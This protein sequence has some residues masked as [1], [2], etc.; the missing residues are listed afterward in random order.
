MV[1]A[2]DSSGLDSKINVYNPDYIVAAIVSIVL[3]ILFFISQTI[4]F[5]RLLIDFGA[6]DG[7]ISKARLIYIYIAG[8]FIYILKL[9]L[10][11]FYI[12][13]LIAMIVVILVL[14]IGLLKVKVP[15]AAGVT[16]VSGADDL[17]TNMKANVYKRVEY[18]IRVIAVYI[19]GF[20]SIKQFMLV[21]LVCI[22]L[23]LFFYYLY[24]ALIIYKPKNIAQDQPDKIGHI[25][26]TNHH[27]LLFLFVTLAVVSIIYLFYLYTYD[28]KVASK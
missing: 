14:L 27:F 3:F 7:A 26:N 25:M 10:A 15:K 17:I 8:Y 16:G 9:L 11:I 24:Y 2:I 20:V 5:N 6:T 18:S 23:F 21:F 22:P 13:I 19:F 12:F 1:A 4:D 28:L